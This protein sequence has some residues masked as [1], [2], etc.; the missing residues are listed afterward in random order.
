MQLSMLRGRAAEK[1][2]RVDRLAVAEAE[3]IIGVDFSD[4]KRDMVLKSLNSRLDDFDAIRK[5]DIPYGTPPALAFYPIPVGFKIP[6]ER[7]PITFSPSPKATRPEK[8]EDVAFW[9]I[10]ELAALV[11]TRQVTSVELTKMYLDRLKKFGPKLQCVVTLTEDLALQQA[12]MADEEIAKGKYRG[13]LHGLPYGAKDLLATK[14]IPTTWGAPPYTNQ[15]FDEDATVI[16]KLRDAG[17]ILVCKTS[18]GELAMGETWFGGK[19]RNPWD[20]KQGSSGSSAGS[21]AGT[22]AGLFAFAIG[23]ETHGSIL[24]P[25]AV[26]GVTGLRPTY[27]RVSRTGCMS[28]SWSMDKIGPICRTVEDCAIVFNAIYGPDDLDQTVYDAPFN[29]SPQADL[30]Q[31]RIGYLKKDFAQKKTHTFDDAALKQLEDLG[32]KLIPMELPTNYPVESISFVLSTEGATFFDELTRNNKD[33]LLVQQ[34]KGSWPNVFRSKRFVPAVEYLQAQRVRYLVIQEMEKVMRDIDVYVAPWDVG[35]N[36]LM[37]NLTGHPG[38]ALPTGFTTN[39]VP[40][41]I[42]FIGKLFGE[43]DLLAVA[44]AYQDATK[45][46]LQRPPEM[47]SAKQAT[48]GK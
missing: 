5:S 25:S 10:G 6:R 22:A 28:L 15:I 37:N 13:L 40:T 41:S 19:T 26:C 39:G 46:H 21:A 27:G 47:L 18:M 36:L 34:E 14:G 20:L 24:S 23:S 44:K 2:N 38:I 30:K 48:I 7:I 11:K 1:T 32:A 45:F 17:S 29:Y 43:A 4:A 16:K 33:D 9:S 8:L 42:S 3:K 35:P 31:L 12:R